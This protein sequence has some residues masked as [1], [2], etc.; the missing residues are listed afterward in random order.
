MN[1]GYL[2]KKYVRKFRLDPKLY[3]SSF[4]ETIMEDYIYEISKHQF[5]R[6][7]TKYLEVINGL[8]VKQYKI[9]SDYGEELKRTNHGSTF[10]IKGSWPTLKRCYLC[11][12]ACKEGFVF[13]CRPVIGLNG[14]FL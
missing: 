5:Y 2:A 8:A 6:T 9:Q 13:G 11:V 7:R 1:V 14:C 12:R 4:I 10:Q 3:M